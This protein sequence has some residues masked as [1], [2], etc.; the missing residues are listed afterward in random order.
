VVNPI[1]A[2][3][4]EGMLVLWGVCVCSED[5]DQISRVLPSRKRFCDFSV[6]DSTEPNQEYFGF[7]CFSMGVG[8]YI[9][10]HIDNVGRVVA[11]SRVQVGCFPDYHAD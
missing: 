7:C 6:Q 8:P 4:P 3:W 1:G 5:K 11:C 10:Q 2:A 9:Q